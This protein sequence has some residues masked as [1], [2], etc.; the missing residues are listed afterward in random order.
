MIFSLTA[1]LFLAA[2]AAASADI[3]PGS[4]LEEQM[5]EMKVPG[6]AVAIVTPDG[7]VT[8]EGYGFA[9]IENGVRAGPDT[10][11]RVGSNSKPVTASAALILASKHAIDL[12]TDIRPLLSD[13]TVRPQ[14]DTPLTLHQLLTHTAGFNEAL[15]G[16]HRQPGDWTPLKPYLKNHLPPR[17]IEPGEIISYVDFHTA[18][19]GLVIEETSGQPFQD[20]TEDALFKPLNMTSSTFRQV[21]IPTAIAERRAKSYRYVGGK[22]IPYPFDAIETTPAAGLS[23]SARDMGKYLQWLLRGRREDV[24]TKAPKAA[25][26]AQLSIQARNH[27][28]LEGRAYGFAERRYNG[29]RVLYKDGQATG[30]N[31]R[32][33]IVP[34]ADIAFFIV[35]NASILEPGGGFA[36]ARR[37]IREFTDEFLARHLINEGPITPVEWTETEPTLPPD[38]Y[39]GH[40]RTSVASRHSWEKLIA[41]FDTVD[42]KV[43]DNELLIADRPANPVGEHLF[44]DANRGSLRAFR[45]VNDR[46]THIFFGPGAYERVSPLESPMISAVIGLGFTMVLTILSGA[47]FF[48]AGRRVVGLFGS[49]ASAL[50]LTFIIGFGYVLFTT[51][52]QLFFHGMTPALQILL[53]LPFIAIAIATLGFSIHLRRRGGLPTLIP[54]IIVAAFCLWLWQWNL[55]G[56]LNN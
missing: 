10:V 28:A 42:V 40:Y 47:S 41:I 11:F 50:C 22:Y 31:A 17:F 23:T 55:L 6:V 48:P 13:L 46:A 4:Y 20:F 21:D 25:V 18:L 53:A 36:D 15:F 35:H 24:E 14:L 1:A 5:T 52:P 38:A 37:L 16:Q 2:P 29:W 43:K 3:W 34:D 19:A 49:V 7:A 51:D 45:V 30:F 54:L 32:L 12:D 9:D 27:P 44:A 26:R 56:W 33:L 8:L 39:A